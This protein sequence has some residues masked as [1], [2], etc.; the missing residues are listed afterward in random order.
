M[1]CGCAP[2]FSRALAPIHSPARA[3]PVPRPQRPLQARV[4]PP[5]QMHAHTSHLLSRFG[6]FLQRHAIDE[7]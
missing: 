2:A 1:A 5:L 3:P 7:R 4:P 6:Q